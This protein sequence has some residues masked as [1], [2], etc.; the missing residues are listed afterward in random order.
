VVKRA[1]GNGVKGNRLWIIEGLK[2]SKKLLQ[3][4]QNGNLLDGGPS[5]SDYTSTRTVRN[6]K[7]NSSPRLNLITIFSMKLANR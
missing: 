7:S 3:Q 2:T 6:H 5:F 4:I 1:V